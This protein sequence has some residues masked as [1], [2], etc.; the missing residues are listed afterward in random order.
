MQPRP[1]LR[2]G[3]AA[4]FH[5]GHQGRLTTTKSAFPCCCGHSKNKPFCDGSHKDAGVMAPG[6]E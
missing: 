4:G 5:A 2:A 1:P 6:Q 3:S